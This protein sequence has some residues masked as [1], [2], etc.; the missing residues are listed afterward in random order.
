M[1]LRNG[2]LE[3]VRHPLRHQYR[4]R[5][6]S[7]RHSH[8]FLL[9]FPH[10]STGRI[11]IRYQRRIRLL[12][13]RKSNCILYG[14]FET[15]SGDVLVEVFIWRDSFSFCFEFSCSNLVFVSTV[16]SLARVGTRDWYGRSFVTEKDVVQF[17][18][19]RGLD[20]LLV[21]VSLLLLN[22]LKVRLSF[23]ASATESK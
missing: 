8:L 16:S 12:Q 23:Y 2:M 13:H 5:Q 21:L 1:S 10:H 3:L 20:L 19:E 7:P 22:D 6:V 15:D 4:Q 18:F 17:N 9:L 11:D 14:I